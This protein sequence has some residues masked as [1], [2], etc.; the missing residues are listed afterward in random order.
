MLDWSKSCEDNQG[1]I[2]GE[3]NIIEPLWA[4]GRNLPQQVVDLL[5]SDLNNELA[6]NGEGVDSEESSDFEEDYKDMKD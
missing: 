6:E 4:K 1:W 3:G 2:R 5:D